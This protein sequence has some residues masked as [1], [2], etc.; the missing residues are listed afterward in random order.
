MCVHIV[1]DM[2]AH[3]H[4][5][6]VLLSDSASRKA[7]RT[8]LWPQHISHELECFVSASLARSDSQALV[9][10]LVVRQASAVVLRLH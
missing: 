9:L 8:A 2:R 6:G 5:S 4:R 7:P 10:E 1:A 3:V